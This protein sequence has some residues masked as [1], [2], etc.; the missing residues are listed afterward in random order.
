MPAIV[1]RHGQQIERSFYFLVTLPAPA[2]MPTAGRSEPR[3]RTSNTAALRS[4]DF[5]AG[6][7]MTVMLRTYR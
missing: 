1:D 6:N 2:R 7:D 3:R 4:Q 5:A